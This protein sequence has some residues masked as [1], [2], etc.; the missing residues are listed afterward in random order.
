MH[1]GVLGPV[2]VRS[3]GKLIDLGGPRQAA[4]LAVLLLD[5][6]GPVL[7]ERIIDLLWADRPPRD[8]SA[9]QVYVSRLRRTLRGAGADRFGV[10]VATTPAGYLLRL[11][12]AALD[13]QRFR[14]RLSEAQARQ[15]GEDAVPLLREALQLWRGPALAG[16]PDPVRQPAAGLEEARLNALEDLMDLEIQAGRHDAVVRYPLRERLRAALMLGLYRAGRKAEALDAFASLAEHLADELGVDPAPAV[17]DLHVAILRDDPDLDAP[18]PARG[19]AGPVRPAQ[20]PTVAA[21]FT[22]RDEHLLELDGL[23]A[24]G[25]RGAP[26][27][28]A[29][30]GTAGVGK[31]A[32]AIYWGHR[33]RHRFPDGQLYVNLRGFDP[34]PT[35]RPVEALAQFLRALGVPAQ[36]VPVELDEAASR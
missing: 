5:S 16:L 33:V 26:A 23:L 2:E 34:G 36:E 3:R 24:A 4:L 10:A 21:H 7:V 14:E 31:T 6:D 25:E 8:R 29:I 32:L 11:G 19:G 9:V 18:P 17:R 27:I 22:G 30:A 28:G 1:F 20:L 35:V 13:A 12:S 15:P